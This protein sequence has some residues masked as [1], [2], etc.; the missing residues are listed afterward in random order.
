[1][2]RPLI[3]RHFSRRDAVRVRCSMS[4]SACSVA[5]RW[6][7]RLYDAAPPAGSLLRVAELFSPGV[8]AILATS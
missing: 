2:D 3:Q 4:T 8:E 1:M 6:G 7:P 5:V